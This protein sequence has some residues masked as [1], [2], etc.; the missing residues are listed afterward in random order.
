MDKCSVGQLCILILEIVN[1]AVVDE[2][3][4]SVFPGYLFLQFCRADAQVDYGDG[5][6]WNETPERQ[7][8]SCECSGK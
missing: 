2:D 1:L 4:S 3:S 7:I 8:F 6:S 5:L